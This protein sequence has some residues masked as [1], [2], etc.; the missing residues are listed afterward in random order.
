[1]PPVA[2]TVG[3]AARCYPHKSKP[4]HYPIRG[5]AP[6]L[7]STHASPK[8]Y[9]DRGNMPIAPFPSIPVV[10]IAA[11]LGRADSSHGPTGRPHPR[12][13][14]GVTKAKLIAR[15]ARNTD[16]FTPSPVF[17][18]H[19]CPSKLCWIASDSGSIRP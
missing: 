4:T 5:S 11:P 17:T 3:H 6:V 19:I 1:M 13:V 12:G 10:T 18:T 15:L 16:K 9:V 2:H 8:E 14:S 7:L